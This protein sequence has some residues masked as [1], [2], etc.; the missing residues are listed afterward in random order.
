[1]FKINSS[2]YLKR[3]KNLF[4]NGDLCQNPCLCQKI[5]LYKD[6]A[7]NILSNLI[8]KKL[9]KKILSENLMPKILFQK[10]YAK[11]RNQFLWFQFDFFHNC[12]GLRMKFRCDFFYRSGFSY[13]YW[14]RYCYFRFQNL[15]LK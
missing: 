11:T 1:M 8:P 4:Q 5:L 2:I 3:N 14:F 7:E 6:Y 15:F 12:D 10:V 13:L 9:S